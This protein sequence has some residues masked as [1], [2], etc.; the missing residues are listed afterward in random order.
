MVFGSLKKEIKISEVLMCPE[1][2]RFYFY[3]DKIYQFKKSP[4]YNILYH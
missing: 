4:N 1:I 2:P 3:L